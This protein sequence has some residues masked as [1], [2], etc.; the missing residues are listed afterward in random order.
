VSDLTNDR[1]WNGSPEIRQ[2]ERLLRNERKGEEQ[3]DRD[4]NR[5]V[6]EPTDAAI[7]RAEE[8]EVTL[9]LSELH[10]F[11]EQWHGMLFK[12]DPQASLTW[13]ASV[14]NARVSSGP[15]DVFTLSDG[16]RVRYNPAAARLEEI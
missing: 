13:G 14:G 7:G 4:W 10:E 15:S 2:A 6:F 1:D 12:R 11:D 16:R 9:S 3:E 5:Y 8:N